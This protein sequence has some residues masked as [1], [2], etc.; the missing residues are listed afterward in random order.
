MKTIFFSLFL[1]VMTQQLPPQV[2]T[3]TSVNY[4]YATIPTGDC[5]TY[6]CNGQC[7]SKDVCYCS[8][9]LA[10]YRDPA[11]QYCTYE[12]HRFAVVVAIEIIFGCGI[13]HLIASNTN[14]GL[15]KM[16]LG[17]GPCI[18]GSVYGCCIGDKKKMPGP[19]KS[20]TSLLGL[21]YVIL[22]LYDIYFFIFKNYRDGNG[23]SL[24]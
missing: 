10:T 22:Y 7:Y 5:S 12:R 23:V 20:I 18:L 21:A 11:N 9:H 6:N 2:T 3:D 8:A 14:Y 19:L 4:N 13:G 16:A 15:I 24:Y 17:L 1:T